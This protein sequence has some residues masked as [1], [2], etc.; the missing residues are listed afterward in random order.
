MLQVTEFICSHSCLYI[1]YFSTFYGYAIGKG[2]EYHP[3]EECW[4]GAQLRYLGLE[5]VGG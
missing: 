4:W 2:K 3:H 1:C 5:L